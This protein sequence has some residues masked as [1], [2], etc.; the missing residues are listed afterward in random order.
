MYQLYDALITKAKTQTQN[1]NQVVS[2]VNAVSIYSLY[3]MSGIFHLI[4]RVSIRA[5]VSK[6]GE[7]GDRTYKPTHIWTHLKAKSFK[8]ITAEI[9]TWFEEAD[10]NLTF[11]YNFIF[12]ITLRYLF[13][14]IYIYICVYKIFLKNIFQPIRHTYNYFMEIC[15]NIL[16]FHLLMP[17]TNSH[18]LTQ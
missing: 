6:W 7:G 14:H 4:K 15:F 13:K 11:D 1:A 10:F 16:L 9:K 12:L 8:K 17:L 2:Y 5:F 18:L 3:M